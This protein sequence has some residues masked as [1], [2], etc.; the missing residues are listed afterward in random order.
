MIVKA[1]IAAL[2]LVSGALIL[3]DLRRSTRVRALLA[4]QRW[5]DARRAAERL[6]ASWMRFLPGVGDGARY[7]V[8]LT[9]H[10]EGDL[11]GCLEALASFDASR[12]RDASVRYGASSLE[13]ATLVLQ[14]REPA[15]ALEAVTAARALVPNAEDAVLAALCLR[16]L[17]RESEAEL[18][19]SRAT[20]RRVDDRAGAELAAAAAAHFFRGLL[21]AR[22]G[23]PV[24]ARTHFEAACRAAPA[25][26]YGRRAEA[27]LA[28]LGPAP[29]Q[30][31]PDSTRSSLAPQMLNARSRPP[32]A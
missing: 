4:A 2:L 12:A 15:R 10:L 30:D 5:T 11:D 18:E 14:G 19:A 7:L 1:A 23:A 25:S 21:Q 22:A 17:A 28:T 6:A 29:D 32:G 16:A 20:S 24:A 27:E 8:A 26:V 13:A 3:R 9:R 31:T